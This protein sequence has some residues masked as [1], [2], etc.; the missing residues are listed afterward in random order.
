V[1]P[2]DGEV[3]VTLNPAAALTGV[4]LDPEG[5]PLSGMRVDAVDAG[6]DTAL[7][8]A[9]TGAAGRFLLCVP[10][11]ARVDL[12]VGGRRFPEG[13]DRNAEETGYRGESR[14]A[15]PGGAEVAIRTRRI[16]CSRS[17]TVLAVGPDGR[18][19]AGVKAIV[20]S[21]AALCQVTRETDDS[22]RAWF[23]G[24]SGEEVRVFAARGDAGAAR[25]FSHPA[26]VRAVPRGQEIVMRFL[27]GEPVRG[28][29]I[30]G[31][32]IPLVGAT[33]DLML[34][35]GGEYLE[36]AVTD[37]EGRFTVMGRPGARHR[38]VVRWRDPD[39]G[40]HRGTMRSVLP[41]DLEVV[42]PV[43]VGPR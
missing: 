4:V 11:E 40:W 13:L 41:S 34:D 7:A 2:E 5:A 33:V 42:F 36:R 38:L 25:R 31:D 12:L 22:G 20:D 8:S 6:S 16:D 39:G 21:R 37:G 18:P 14:G 1:S 29:V 24:L 17:L 26:T 3:E 28:R 10:P 9:V 35:G 27:P 43:D 32:G 19:L 30:G 23:A 15:V